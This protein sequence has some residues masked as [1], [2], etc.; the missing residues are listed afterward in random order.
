MRNVFLIPTDKPSKIGSCNNQLVFLPK[1]QNILVGHKD[2]PT[3][4][5][6]IYITSD[7]T[8]KAGDYWIDKENIVQKTNFDLEYSHKIIL[9]T[10]ETLIKSGVQVIYDEFLNWFV[11]NPDCEW[12][13]VKKF[14][15]IYSHHNISS[16]FLYRIIIPQVK[17][18][19]DINTC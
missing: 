17:S 16:E 2:Y 19:N 8:P 11:N 9:T 7:E 15:P 4:N 1:H 3:I 10:D 18:K 5:Q 13:E 14:D 6:N 12:V